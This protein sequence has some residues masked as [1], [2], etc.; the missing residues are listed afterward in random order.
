MV[1]KFKDGRYVTADNLHPGLPRI[2]KTDANIEKVRKIQWENH[3]MSIL[4]V[5][6]FKNIDNETVQQILYENL[7]WTK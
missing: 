1:K 6:E 4:V 2:P 3:H 7:T 5:A